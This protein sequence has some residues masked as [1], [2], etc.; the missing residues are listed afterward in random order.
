MVEY[1]Y[2][3]QDQ[4]GWAKP[5]MLLNDSIAQ[6]HHFVNNYDPF[7]NKKRFSKKLIHHGYFYDFVNKKYYHQTNLS[8]KYRYLNPVDSAEYK[9]WVFTDTQKSIVGFNC[10]AALSI[11]ISGDSTL[12]FYTD[13][14]K[15]KNGFLFYYGVPGVVLEAYEQKM[16]QGTA[17]TVHL[18]ATVITETDII[19]V[20]P[21]KPRIVTREE[22]EK[23]MQERMQQLEL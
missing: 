9:Q 6:I 19:L 15:Y 14:L 12:V 3:G 13:E 21:E 16:I 10:K 8:K 23:F 4:S 5:R 17:M 20:R 22:H 1:K 7:D 2:I 11:N 18:I